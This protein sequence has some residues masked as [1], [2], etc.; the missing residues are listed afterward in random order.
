QLRR[1]TILLLILLSLCLAFPR[2][3]TQ[4]VFAQQSQISA[5][6]RQETFNIV[7]TT[8]KEKH[9]DPTLGGVNWDKVRD[10]YEP[11]A[12]Q[13]KTDREFYRVLQQMLEELHQSHFQIIPPE[14][15][16]SDDSKEPKGGGI[17]IDVR[18]IDGQA[19]I[20]RV[21]PGSTG[22]AAGLRTGFVIQKVD[23]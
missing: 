1:P 7:W 17:G 12:R 19:V 23:E 20:S 8:V 15:I 22:Y 9:W 21:D 3:A 14:A 10:D 6:T 11:R 4:R 13:A 16:V 5:D 2:A 18:L